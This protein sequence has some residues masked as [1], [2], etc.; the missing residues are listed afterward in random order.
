MPA[1]SSAEHEAI[2]NNIDIPGIGSEITLSNGVKLKLGTLI[3]LAGDYYGIPGTPIALG[4][5]EKSQD[6]RFLAAFNTL[7]N[8]NPEDIKKICAMIADERHNIETVLAEG[9]LEREALDSNNVSETL[10]SIAYTNANYVPLAENNIDHFAETAL[11]AYQSGHRLAIK[12]ALAARMLADPD[13]QTKMMHHAFALEGFACHFLTDLFAAGHMR[14]PRLQLHQKFGTQIGALLSLFQHEEDGVEGLTVEDKQ[15]HSWAAFGDGH[16]FDGNSEKNRKFA[17]AAVKQAISEVH[18]AF[19]AGEEHRPDVSVFDLIPKPAAHNPSPLFRL[20]GD[21]LM[22]RKK[23]DDVHST[24]YKEISN[25][26][27]IKILPHFALHYMKSGDLDNIMAQIKSETPINMV[28][29]LPN[30]S[31]FHHAKPMETAKTADPAPKQHCA[32]TVL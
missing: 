26:S 6:K 15:G 20:E 30:F 27:L 13:E 32:C 18:Q 25:L 24:A 29:G 23:L 19:L 2:G 22:Y 4:K 5:N 10:Q 9:K 11:I 3:A 21:K 14:T 1:F 28:S 16:L 12:A 31:I 8:A 7:D 17:Q